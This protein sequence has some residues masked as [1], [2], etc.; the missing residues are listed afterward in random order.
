MEGSSAV[1]GVGCNEGLGL[2]FRNAQLLHKH[3]FAVLAQQRGRCE[4]V[5]L[6][7]GELDL[8]AGELHTAGLGV[9][10][11]HEHLAGA[12]DMGIL[13]HPVDGVD[14]RGRNPLVQH[15]LH[16]VV[17]GPI[18]QPVLD[19]GLEVGMVQHAARCWR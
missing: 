6:V 18:L 14:G 4:G 1:Y 11:L 3:L 10:H 9:V 16:R 5:D 12:G 7:V 8:V 15:G 13:H 17:D 19:N 2:F